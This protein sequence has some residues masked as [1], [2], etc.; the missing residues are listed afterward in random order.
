[1]H[2][3]I[4]I[5]TMTL[6]AT[7]EITAR[8]FVRA[9]GSHATDPGTA[10]GVARTNAAIGEPFAVDVLGLLEI[11]AGGPIAVGNLLGPDPYEGRAVQGD[12]PLI[13]ITAATAAGETVLATSSIG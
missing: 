12:G 8:R 11:E 9:D 7:Y 13:A 5:L 1:M 10:I 6:R 4:P 3:I 2:A